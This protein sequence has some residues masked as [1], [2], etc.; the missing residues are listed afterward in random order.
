MRG[1]FGGFA[2]RLLPQSRRFGSQLDV[3]MRKHKATIESL[4][5]R[6]LL[7]KR[8]TDWG[9]LWGE[10]SAGHSD[11]DRAFYLSVLEIREK[12]GSLGADAIIGMRHDMD[13]DSNKRFQYFY[14]QMYGTAVGFKA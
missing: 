5:A 2:R 3:L 14:L 8:R 12:A 13:L 6:D 4:K 1:I 11:F 9:I 7:E 10:G